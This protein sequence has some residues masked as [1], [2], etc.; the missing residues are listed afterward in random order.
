MPDFIAGAYSNIELARVKEM[1]GNP[2]N[3]GQVMSL[4]GL[5]AAGAADAQGYVE[6]NQRRAD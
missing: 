3:L 2:A 6:I 4:T 1:L 5:G